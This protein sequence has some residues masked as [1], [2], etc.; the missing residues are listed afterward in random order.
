MTTSD[1]SRMS[2]GADE[3]AATPAVEPAA[4]AGAGRRAHSPST[5]TPPR[6]RAPASAV[7]TGPAPTMNVVGLRAVTAGTGGAGR[8]TATRHAALAR[9]RPTRRGPADRE[10]ASP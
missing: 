9:S 5:G 3:K 1:S 7:A 10:R 2:G 6:R 8:Y 4:R